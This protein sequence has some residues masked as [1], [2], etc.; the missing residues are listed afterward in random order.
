[1]FDYITS[2]MVGSAV[3]LVVVTTQFNAQRSAV[4]ETINYA[5]QRAILE[6]AE[7]LEDDLILIGDGTDDAI[8]DVDTNDDDQTTLFSF[9]RE[10]ESGTEIL[11]SYTLTETDVVDVEGEKTQLYRLDR[12]EDKVA[13]G[14][15]SSTLETFQIE[16][17][18]S[19]GSVTTDPDNARLIR[20]RAVNLYPYGDPSD[21]NHF[22]NYWGI[23]VRPPALDDDDD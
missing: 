8:E 2:I 3:L 17:L 16:M 12:F 5:S 13:A 14:G 4:E 21:L 9:W 18:N 23:T 19:S 22:R 15:G 11:V 10:D 1:M 20:V 7:Y 6:F